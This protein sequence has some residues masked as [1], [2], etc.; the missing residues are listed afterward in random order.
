MVSAKKNLVLFQLRVH[1]SFKNLIS[2]KWDSSLEN[3]KYLF[4][5][6]FLKYGSQY[7]IQSEKQIKD[8]MKEFVIYYR[9]LQISRKF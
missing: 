8:E 9:Q 6:E 5:N 1:K 4:F 7:Q 2:Q 3:P